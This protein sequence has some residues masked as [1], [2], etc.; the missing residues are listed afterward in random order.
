[1]LRETRSATFLRTRRYLRRRMRFS[2]GGTD[3]QHTISLARH[4]ELE[5]L[6][7]ER[8]V[9]V[10]EQGRR[11]HWWFHDRF[12]WEDDAL[13]AQDVMALVLD[14]ERR[15]RRRLERAHA[16]LGAAG[17]DGAAAGPAGARPALTLELKRA[18]W[19]R[20]GGR[21]AE[22]GSASLLEFDHIIPLA[23][24]GS[25]GERN[26]QLLCAECNRAKADAL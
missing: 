9:P 26:L 16:L 4:A 14:R 2:A 19:E 24:G 20:C 17:G 13:T 10:A 11:R 15:A 3:A 22:C 23:L 21:C 18:V 6:Q 7:R 8:P 25:N 1:M 12:W 5:A